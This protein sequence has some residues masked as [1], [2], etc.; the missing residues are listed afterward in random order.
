MLERLDAIIRLTEDIARTHRQIETAC[1][2]SEQVLRAL[3]AVEQDMATLRAAGS[4]IARM[5]ADFERSLPTFRLPD[6]AS[7]FP[8]VA[9]PHTEP[10][11]VLDQLATSPLGRIADLEARV[12]QLEQLLQP[13]SPPDD[14]EDARPAS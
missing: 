7:L 4:P 2:P 3:A 1:R 5:L 11:V 10:P 14:G 9:E 12:E 8:A 13:P 6:F